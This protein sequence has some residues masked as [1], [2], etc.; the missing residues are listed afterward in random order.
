[1][2]L[3]LLN[4]IQGVFASMNKLDNLLERFSDSILKKI[5]EHVIGIQ[6]FQFDVVC[7]EKSIAKNNFH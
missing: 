3:L 2:N 6:C 4:K 5:E 7:F 1:M